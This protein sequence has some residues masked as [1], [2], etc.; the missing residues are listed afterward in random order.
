MSDYHI[1]SKNWLLAVDRASHALRFFGLLKKLH[2]QPEGISVLANG[3]IA[4]VDDHRGG[5]GRL[6][7]YHVQNYEDFAFSD[8]ARSNH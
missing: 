8:I 5:R 2:S 4:I 6:T 3:S 7:D 1:L